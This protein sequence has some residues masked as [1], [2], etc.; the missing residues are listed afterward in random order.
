[1][2]GTEIVAYVQSV[3]TID[4]SSF[5]LDDYLLS[6]TRADVDCNDVRCPVTEAA[7]AMRARIVELKERKDSTG[8][9]VCYK[10]SSLWSQRLSV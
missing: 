9:V 10:V 8:G 3:G 5:G 4:A 6:V 1:M 2:F 7:A